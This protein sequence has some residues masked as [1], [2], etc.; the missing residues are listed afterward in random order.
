[1]ATETQIYAIGTCAIGILANRRNAQKS[2]GPHWQKV[3]EIPS[4]TLFLCALV[5]LWL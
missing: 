4:T 1:M 5:A 2:T 3:F